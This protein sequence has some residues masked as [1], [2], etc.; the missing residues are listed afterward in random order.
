M[1]ALVIFDIGAT[2]VTG[3]DRGPSRR[4]AE[5]LCL[6][7]QAETLLES[8]LMNNAW[9]RPE[10]VVDF[11]SGT[12]CLA[13]PDTRAIVFEIWEAQEHEALAIPGAAEAFKRVANAGF[14]LALVSNIWHP[15]LLSVRRIYGR[16]FDAFVPTTHQFFSYRCGSAKPAPDMFTAA[17][18]TTGIPPDRAI[19]IGD[20]F[21]EDIEPAAKLGLNTVWTLHRPQKEARN[22]VCILN[23]QTARP[24]WTLN[25]IDELRTDTLLGLLRDPAC[26]TDHRT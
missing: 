22:V 7:E 24:S 16:L 5:R 9:E 26:T 4:M 10:E 12:L 18:A 13:P 1:E 8:A 19:M 6:A 17:L 14:R 2:L 21:R 25:A 3:P 20:F 11:L 15:Y 23:G